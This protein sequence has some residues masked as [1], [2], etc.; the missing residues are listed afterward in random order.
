MPSKKIV[1]DRLIYFSVDTLV[2]TQLTLESFD[3]ASIDIDSITSVQR[4][5][6]NKSWIVTFASRAAKEAALEIQH[7]TMSGLSVFLG[8]CDNHLALVKIYEAPAELPDTP[9]HRAQDCGELAKCSVCRAEDHDISNCPFVLFSANVNNEPSEEKS[10]EQ[11]Q[12]EKEERAKRMRERIEDKR[13]QEELKR[14]QGKL[15]RKQKELKRKQEEE[16][17]RKQDEERQRQQLDD[18][19]ERR[20]NSENE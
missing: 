4:K 9:G 15:K 20:R 18:R 6:S 12:K 17:K 7:V 10:D 1:K 11:K 5:S 8:D 13:K 19:R 2:T 16:Q 14:K 3:A